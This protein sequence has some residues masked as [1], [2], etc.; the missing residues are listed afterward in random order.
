MSSKPAIQQHVAIWRETLSSTP[1]D[2]LDVRFRAL[3]IRPRYL[4]LAQP[5]RP[6]NSDGLRSISQRIIGVDAEERWVEDNPAEARASATYNAPEG[7]LRGARLPF[8]LVH[9]AS[10]RYPD[11]GQVLWNE[12]TIQAVAEKYLSAGSWSVAAK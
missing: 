2:P 5:R 3:D 12:R 4:P 10:L 11:I 1:F 6:F 9:Q 7:C 8:S